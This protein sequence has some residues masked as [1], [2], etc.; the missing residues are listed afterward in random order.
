MGNKN[1]SVMHIRSG[2]YLRR[3]STEIYFCRKKVQSQ[4]IGASDW[5]E[6]I[7]GDAQSII[8]LCRDIHLIYC[9]AGITHVILFPRM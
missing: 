5:L 2:A 9:H 7:V 3:T 4:K 8:K 1:V 6:K